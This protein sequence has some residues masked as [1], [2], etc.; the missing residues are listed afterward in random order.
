MSM[1]DQTNLQLRLNDGG[2]GVGCGELGRQQQIFQQQ[3]S[4]ANEC[5]D[6]DM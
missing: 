3:N 6:D 2:G 5:T 1:C 4:N